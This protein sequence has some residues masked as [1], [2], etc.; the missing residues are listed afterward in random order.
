MVPD[1]LSSVFYKYFDAHFGAARWPLLFESMGQSDVKVA[2]LNPFLNAG[3]ENIEIKEIL[4]QKYL[5]EEQ[6]RNLPSTQNEQ[7]PFY[8]LDLASLLPPLALGLNPGESCLDMCAAPG[9]KTLIVASLL[10]P[11]EDDLIDLVA[12]EISQD[13]RSRLIRVL[14]EQL[15]EK[16]FRQI[17]ITAHDASKWCLYQKDHYDKIL[18]DGPCSGERYFIGNEKEI[19]NWS[20]KRSQ[21]MAIRQFAILASAFEC[22]KVGG[23]AV[24]STCSISPFENDEVMRKLLKKRTGR[25]EVLNFASPIGERTEF[26][27]Q[28]LPDQCSGFG[29]IYFSLIKRIS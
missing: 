4:G 17:K 1:T 16:L 24:Y 7:R 2:R 12:N 8:F 14:K 9:G 6:A 22:L 13:R 28:I 15:P 21:N 29:P 18:L 27:W 3:L 25:V 10:A 23:S 26:G 19:Q 20:R 5:D 11:N